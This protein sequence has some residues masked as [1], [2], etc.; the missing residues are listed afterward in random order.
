MASTE[1]YGMANGTVLVVCTECGQSV[2]VKREEAD[3]SPV[4]EEFRTT[5]ECPPPEEE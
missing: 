5:H 3:N 1:T 2:S 4:L